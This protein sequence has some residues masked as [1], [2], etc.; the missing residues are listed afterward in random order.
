VLLETEQL[1]THHAKNPGDVPDTVQVCVAM[2]LEAVEETP[3]FQNLAE[4]RGHP[5]HRVSPL[6]L[7]TIKMADRPTTLQVGRG[8]PV[9]SLIQNDRTQDGKVGVLSG[10]VRG[11]HHP[12][13]SEQLI[14]S[15]CPAFPANP[16]AVQ[17][18]HLRGM[19][20]HPGID[21]SRE[22]LA[23][24]AERRRPFGEAL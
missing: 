24:T 3:R 8:G 19:A 16:I 22:V 7:N 2:F 9:S 20:L 23:E 10:C 17:H 6:V 4:A 21:L 15:G 5:Q 12:E 13:G 18:R 14:G 1:L 11:L